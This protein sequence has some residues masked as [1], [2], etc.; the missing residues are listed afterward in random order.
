[1]R[2]QEELKGLVVRGIITSTSDKQSEKFVPKTPQKTIYFTVSNEADRK[3]LED[4]GLTEY[5]GAKGTPEEINYFMVKMSER[6]KHDGRVIS[7]IAGEERNFT[8]DGKVVA[9]ALLKGEN[10]G[11]IFYR[12]TAIHGILVENEG[13]DP[14]AD[15]DLSDIE[16]DPF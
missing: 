1:M 7:G 12:C 11:N 2:K 15:M 6:V 14:F 9:L 13:V 8:S 10:V 4:F 5:T 16:V 3:K